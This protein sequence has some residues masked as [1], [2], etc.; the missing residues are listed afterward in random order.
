[1]CGIVNEISRNIAINKERVW[2][3]AHCQLDEEV[4]HMATRKKV[5]TDIKLTKQDLSCDKLDVLCWSEALE[6]EEIFGNS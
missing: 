1:M 6:V 3:D 5:A 4:F 2:N